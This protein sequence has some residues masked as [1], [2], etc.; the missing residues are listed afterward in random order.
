MSLA[1]WRRGKH[2]PRPRGNILGQTNLMLIQVLPF[3]SKA[4]VPI[5]VLLSLAY[6]RKRFPIGGRELDSRKIEELDERFSSVKW[7]PVLCMV[8]VGFL[9]VIGT[10]AA[11]AGLN[12]FLAVKDDPG[13]IHLLPQTAIWWFFPGFGALALSWEITLQL[14]SF[15]GY[16]KLANL[17]N[18]WSN[19]TTTMG[20]WG[21]HGMDSRKILRILSL[22][23]ALP[24]FLFTVL[25]LPMHASVGQQSIV[26]CGYAFKPCQ[27]YPLRDA[28][29]ITSIKGF[30]TKNGDFKTRAGLV[31]DFE[32]GRR[33]SSAEWDDWHQRIDPVLA[34]VLEG[35]T[36]LPIETADTEEEIPLQIAKRR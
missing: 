31:V 36:G 14:W 15:C 17:Y 26:D 32:D 20:G 21:A 23:V 4:L 25:A 30:R 35:R 10:H 5:V 13:A 11:L 6:F 22:V 8:L 19:V 24:I 12:R 9:F 18:D 34:Q 27:S 29:R 7:I 28:R 3:L 1:F 33:W 16:R 2:E